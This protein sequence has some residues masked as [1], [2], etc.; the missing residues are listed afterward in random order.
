MKKYIR[1]I[2]IVPVLLLTVF[3]FWG[4]SCSE[5]RVQSISISITES[6]NVTF[7]GGNRYEVVWDE[8]NPY[9]EINASIYP[10]G[11]SVGDLEWTSSSPS[12]A[13]FMNKNRGL[14]TCIRDGSISV[15]ASLQGVSS[16]IFIEIVS[17]SSTRFPS[18]SVQNEYTGYDQK[19][20][21]LVINPPE[22]EENYTYS[23][24][25]NS[26]GERV[27]EIKNV[28]EY[29]IVY[30]RV[31]T[32]EETSSTT[33]IPIDQ[34]SV[35]ITP[36][37]IIQR[38]E[39]GSSL[40]GA[41]L[42]SGFYSS[43]DITNELIL[44]EGEDIV[45]GVGEDDG[46]VI[47]K[48]VYSSSASQGDIVGTYYTNFEYVLF[49]E[50]KN[51]YE[52]TTTSGLYIV[53]A[54]SVVLKVEDQNITYM[55]S[56]IQ[57]YFS[58]YDYNEYVANNNSILG[59]RPLSNEEANYLD[60]IQVTNYTYYQNNEGKTTNEWG[61][62]NAG[63]YDITYT[64]PTANNNLS[65]QAVLSGEIVVGRKPIS[66]TPTSNLSKV[67]GEE[68]DLS[69]LA[70]TTSSSVITQEIKPFLNINYMLSLE[71]D[72]VLTPGNSNAPV[73]TYYYSIDNL[74]NPNY[75]FTLVEEATPEY[76]DEDS[77]IVFRVT[78]GNISILF[79]GYSGNFI[80][81]KNGT[82]HVVS[83]YNNASADFKIKI[84][85]FKI[86]DEE[87]VSDG[88]LTCVS[89]D[90]ESTGMF[91]LETGE[92]FRVSL[93]L[94][95][96]IT[97]DGYYET[98]KIGFSSSYYE[99]GLETNYTINVLPSYINL[100]KI[101]LTITPSTENASKI[102]DNT[103]D[104]S[105]IN[106]FLSSYSVSGSIE[107]GVSI[108]QIVTDKTLLTL[109]NEDGYYIRVDGEREIEEQSFRNAGVYKVFLSSNIIY[110]TGREYYEFVLDESQEYYFTVE[111]KDIVIIPN[112]DQ[113]KYYGASDPVLGYEIDLN[114]QVYEDGSLRDGML[115]REPGENVGE[116][117]INLGSLSFGENYSLSVKP[118]VI[119][120]INKRDITVTPYS[121]TTTYGS[122]EP[123]SIS[124]ELNIDI[125]N[126]GIYDENI[127][128]EPKFTGDFD[129]QYENANVSK[130]GG[131][132]PVVFDQDGDIA[133][134]TITQGKFNLTEESLVNY[135]L[136]VTETSTFTV[137]PKDITINIVS[138]TMN[139]E[140]I[141]D[142]PIV[143][144]ENQYSLTP[145]LV[146]GTSISITVNNVVNVE[147]QA[148]YLIDSINDLSI[149]LSVSGVATGDLEKIQNSY[150]FSLGDR[151]L[152]YV[153]SVVI[154][155]KLVAR[156]TNESVVE[157]TYNGKSMADE[158]VL[159]STNS[160]FVL[161]DE[162]TY[163]ID[164]STTSESGITPIN[165]GGYNVSV[166]IEE[167][168]SLVLENKNDG[169]KVTFT[170]FGI[171]TGGYIAT[172]SQYG[173]LTI[174]RATIGY[175][176]SLV[177]FSS[178]L[179]YGNGVDDLSNILEESEGEKVFS[180]VSLDE[181]GGKE[182]IS[183]YVQDGKN[184]EYV[185]SSSPIE[186]LTAGT[187][188]YITVRVRAA[189]E[190]GEI[191]ANYSPLIIEVPLQVVQR[192]IVI[193]NSPPPSFESPAGDE[194][195]VYNGTSM[196]YTLKLTA[197]N[198][199]YSLSYRYILLETEYSDSSA[200]TVLRYTTNGNSVSPML[201]DDDIQLALSI[202]EL[203]NMISVGVTIQNI[204]G[205]NYLVVNSE[206]GISECYRIAMREDVTPRNAGIYVCFATC[207]SNTNYILSY[208]GETSGNVEFFIAFEIQKSGN[209]TVEN[210][211]ED[212]Y[213][214]TIF[215]IGNEST[216]PFEYTMS[217]N[218]KDDV[219]YVTNNYEEWAEVNFIL[220]VGNYS[221]TLIVNNDNYYFSNDLNFNVNSLEAE[222]I[223][224]SD[225][226]FV[227]RDEPIISFLS[228]I[229][230]VLK[231]MNGNNVR[232][233]EYEEDIAS[234]HFEYYTED[235]S[236][237]EGAPSDVGVYT[238]H[239]TYGAKTEA[240][241]GEGEFEYEIVKRA[242]T[243]YVRANDLSRPYNPDYTASDIY[244]FMF[245]MFDCSESPQ[246]YTLTIVDDNNPQ[247]IFSANDETWVKNVNDCSSPKR[248]RFIMT[249][250]DGVTANREIRANLTFTKL[251]VTSSS[252]Q[253]GSTI[254][255]YNY[256][257]YPVYKELF[258]N[259]IN[260]SP[261]TAGTTETV[262]DNGSTYTIEYGENYRVT[263]RDSLGNLIF[264]IGY[265]YS[266]YTSDT[267]YNATSKPP[268]APSEFKYRV[269]YEI[270]SF[271]TNYERNISSIS[272]SEFLITK[273]NNIY[274]NMSAFQDVT[275]TGQDLGD[276]IK[277]ANIR[278]SNQQGSS[279][280]N[281][282]VTILYNPSLGSSISYTE[283]QGVCLI[284]RYRDEQGQFV[285]ELK[286]AGDYDIVLSFLYL[287]GEYTLSKYFDYVYF[288]N[289]S[290]ISVND[291]TGASNLMYNKTLTTTLKIISAESPY[292][293]DNFMS[294]FDVE[295]E[296]NIVKDE[297]LGNILE[298]Y[299]D[300]KIELKSD[301]PFSIK[302]YLGAQELS[303]TSFSEL[304]GPSDSAEYIEYRL[305][306][307]DKEGN[308]GES[309]SITI[310]KKANN[311]S[312][313]QIK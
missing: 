80:S 206:S 263:L 125:V 236:L 193:S 298:F 128:V 95:P 288:G 111:P 86:N 174:S 139:S 132:Y 161:S 99:I 30:Y 251:A 158:F 70:Y 297:A 244:G 252:L 310:R 12:I 94:L 177:G 280:S 51:N 283:E 129:L 289:A 219:E 155:L 277:S 16:T 4:C 33:L 89:E 142:P 292:N 303:Y 76:E 87:M 148:R 73:G 312:E 311:S 182:E 306:I 191:N 59:I 109:I 54:R 166:K 208:E 5:P 261:G 207:S 53:S 253:V 282:K 79:E 262:I 180:G 106:N 38:A 118:G 56:P 58:L 127:L 245:S 152:Y 108:D 156:G 140:D 68:D 213:Y 11:F 13:T 225:N 228:D 112:E 231:D 157:R 173:Y 287:P 249:F 34:M 238:L 222:F 210:W 49:D 67:Y 241:F 66:V 202:A 232:I 62:L 130:V 120:T 98:Y 240:Y 305:V 224:P 63:T 45:L 188:H 186:M 248:I 270:V 189:N 286:D 223:F 190:Q 274:I 198:N 119:F 268:I 93:R 149:S 115:S 137:Q 25:D 8:S 234:F 195:M 179:T 269:G 164:Y 46:E 100:S 10:T 242:Y 313:V 14:L 176:S 256:T 276:I 143:L 211:K 216:L 265:N 146:S 114:T 35:T 267:E 183:L 230:V 65:I 75:N 7:L 92:K 237:C 23:Y 74:V 96:D 307:Y 290:P 71:S 299:N 131:Y 153:N 28:G 294:A 266:Y 181:N 257:G 57:E 15:T 168:Q 285:T 260:L 32:D 301:V 309:E 247:I 167:G 196:Y 9:V 19:D 217:P 55:S 291:F 2:S 22:D 175:N 304:P 203:Q 221:I 134:Y 246:N 135:N 64:S 199:N 3:F 26:T 147:P 91:V 197:D 85:S 37:K 150:K 160:E 264:T 259:G 50:Y 101:T 159:M 281:M 31:E 295:G 121:Y 107:E 123:S 227:Y 209:I 102:Y 126:A 136:V 124:Y 122:S 6:E 69:A 278:V 151:V 212:F 273:I 172:V 48:Y 220:G 272:P 52:V 205:S 97:Q 201:S 17:A 218:Y 187:T 229:S 145:S 104:L 43:T 61:Y 36:Y 42:Q 178:A 233:V 204:G 200:G 103:S 24:F 44:E 296:Y 258:Y 39:D 117:E 154:S 243:G 21:Y 81:P 184:F 47:G 271:G 171:A 60:C 84:S 194:A 110:Q 165:V 215:N 239:A 170:S 163:T 83:Y 138:R 308:Y 116:Y 284:V 144:Q 105:G 18:S 254:S 1:Y 88:T 133:S 90:F 82:E 113:A 302:F 255:E 78:E 20:S 250:N 279:P 293:R 185:N 77:K 235:G 214:G 300:T 40:F 29:D 192:Q 226:R 72:F 169:S 41:S 27:N 141:K 162:S 275:Y